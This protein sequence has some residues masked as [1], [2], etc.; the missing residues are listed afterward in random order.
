MNTYEV[1]DA[2]GVLRN[3]NELIDENLRSI[4]TNTSSTVA[5]ELKIKEV[6]YELTRYV[7]SVNEILALAK[8]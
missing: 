7:K 2:F 5:V 8:N 6:E 1:K 3:S 4:V